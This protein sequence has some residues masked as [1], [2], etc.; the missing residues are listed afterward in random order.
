MS[1]VPLN[2]VWYIDHTLGPSRL[3]R[4]PLLN[5]SLINMLPPA[6]RLSITLI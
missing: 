3:A 6:P 2:C 5:L 4:F 1:T